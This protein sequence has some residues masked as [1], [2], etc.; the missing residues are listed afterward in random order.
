MGVTYLLW[1]KMYNS[2]QCKCISSEDSQIVPI[3]EGNNTTIEPSY[4]PT[5]GPATSSPTA[6]PSKLPS[7]HPT[8]Q[9]TLQPTIEI[10]FVQSHFVG[11]YKISAQTSSHGNWLLCD[12]SFIDPNHYPQLFSVIGYSFGSKVVGTVN[13][14]ALPDV[15]DHVVGINGNSYTM[16]TVTGSESVSLNEDNLPSHWHYLARTVC[17]GAYSSSSKPHLATYCNVGAGATFSDGNNEYTL[18]ATHLSPTQFK[19]SSVGSGTPINIMQP[20][21]FVGNLFIYAD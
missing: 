12:G 20:T 19:S 21:V 11:D 16:G 14:F 5:H 4:A 10:Q 15:E 2:N 7:E 3:K 18:E 9:P 13:R 8:A 17:S 6:Y 1:D